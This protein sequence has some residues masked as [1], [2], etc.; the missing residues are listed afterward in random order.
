MPVVLKTSALL[1]I[2]LAALAFLCVAF[3]IAIH[4][5][6]LP[7]G[8]GDFCIFCW[9]L[10]FSGTLLVILVELFGLQTRAPV[11]WKNFPI[12]FAC[13]AALLCLSASIIFPLYFLKGSIG[14]SEV[15]DFRLL[16]TIFSCLATVAYLGEVI[17]TKARPGEVSGYMATTPGLLKALETFVACIIFVFISEPVLYD[18]HYT[19]KY[20]MSVYCICFIVSTVIILL[21]I[22]GR[23]GCLPFPF[24]R[25]LYTYAMLAVVLYLSVT[26][27][28]PVFHF[29]PRHGGQK[30]R[31]HNCTSTMGLCSWDK[32]MAVAVLTGVNFILYLA[33]L[34]YTNR[35][36]FVST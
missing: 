12:T 26:V 31:P 29:D 8:T 22:S 15:H 23:T 21:C 32:A 5:G 27:I 20:C 24:T 14:Q 9:G 16:S 18:H 1:W 7:H 36:M 34:I 10:S 35:L 6:K 17:L 28:W 33:D 11:S 2:R 4:G 30:Q 3:S 25:F 13:Y 19:G